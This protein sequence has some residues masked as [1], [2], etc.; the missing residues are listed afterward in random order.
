[1]TQQE[2][3]IIIE[4]LVERF[5]AYDCF[6]IVD[7]TS[8][9]VEA[10]NHFRRNCRQKGVVYQVA[11]NTLIVKALDQL[12]SSID[13]PT[14]RNQVLKGFSGILFVQEEG[15]LPANI[16]KDFRKQQNLDKPILKG[17]SIGGE[18][19]IG[20]AHLEALSKLKSR[21]V[22]IGEIITLLKAPITNV[23]SALQSGSS[24]LTGVVKT[25]QN[26]NA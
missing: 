7:P 13:L 18:L 21:K 19:F 17:A 9:S 10:I 8:I 22:L 15:S 24:T 11:K 25:L 1:M 4:G 20:E 26:R 5:K 12:D 6:Y 23:V 14:L 2:K 3:S 16:V